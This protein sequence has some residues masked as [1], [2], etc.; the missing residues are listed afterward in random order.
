[1]SLDDIQELLALQDG[2][3]LSCQQ[4]HSRLLKKIDHIDETIAKRAF[5]KGVGCSELR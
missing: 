1:L 4:V 2:E 3:Q 5:E